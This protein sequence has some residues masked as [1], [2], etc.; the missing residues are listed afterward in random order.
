M[1]SL[2]GANREKLGKNIRGRLEKGRRDGEIRK[3]AGR[4]R[5]NQKTVVRGVG[6]TGEERRSSHKK[7]RRSE[8]GAGDGR[9]GAK[10]IQKT[11]SFPNE[12]KTQYQS[13]TK[14]P[15]APSEKNQ[16]ERRK[17]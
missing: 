17:V 10:K 7:E 5:R 1:R 13:R 9:N 3:Q 6:G 14:P 16:Q 11:A 12:K 15:P 2:W 4:S 8:G